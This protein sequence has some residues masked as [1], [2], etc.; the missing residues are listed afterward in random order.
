[1]S[2]KE[3]PSPDV[4]GLIS[5]EALE[6]LS[7][8]MVAKTLYFDIPDG[9]KDNLEFIKLRETLLEVREFIMALAA[10]DL[11]CSLTHKGYIPGILKGLQAS[12]RHL[13]WQT[14]M[15]AS[16][17]F[18]Q[19][20]DFMGEFAESF[21]SMVRQLD[22][23]MRRLRQHEMELERLARTDQLTGANNR[24]YFL[25]LL[26]VEME[27]SRRYSS[28][29]S[30]LML[31]L[32]HFKTV[33]DT[34]G[35]AAGDEALRSLVSALNK[36]GL[37]RSDFFGRMGGEE[38]AVTLPET[39]LKMA[40]IV[41]ERIRSI[42]EKTEVHYE[43]ALFFITASIGVA[44]YRE[45]DTADT[46]LHRADQAMYEAKMTGRNRVCLEM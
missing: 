39:D 34:R 44:R 32:D 2:G 42:L 3:S 10:G 36:S 18:S 41:A 23:N 33:N 46:L 17:D 28:P 29:L 40:C 26:D 9:L 1:M 5:T 25:E 15:I 16:G 35:H 30:L 4:C 43:G 11:S 24:G 14:G 37:R 12:L 21:N 13:T 31:D 19:R 45:E 8:I 27:R 38:F 7:E 6:L 22:E 20:V